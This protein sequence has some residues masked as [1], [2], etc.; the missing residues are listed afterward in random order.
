MKNKTDKIKIVFQGDN[1]NGK[2]RTMDH[3]KKSLKQVWKEVNLDHEEHTIE[4]IG[5]K[6]RGDKTTTEKI[7][8]WAR[9]IL[10]ILM[11]FLLVGCI[12]RLSVLW[13]ILK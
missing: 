9:L 8:M 10:G 12:F 2:S 13:G 7:I 5:T 11:G 4:C 6:K 3:I 1:A